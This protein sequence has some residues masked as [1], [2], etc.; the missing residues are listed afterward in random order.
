VLVALTYRNR[1]AILGVASMMM[2]LAVIA[3]V[4]AGCGGSR[5]DEPMPVPVV[6][7]APAVP[8]PADKAVPPTDKAVPPADKAAAVPPADTADAAPLVV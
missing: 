1:W 4:V 6:P 8:P 5:I 3:L 7:A 2:K